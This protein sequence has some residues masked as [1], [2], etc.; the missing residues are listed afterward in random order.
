MD[1]NWK[2]SQLLKIKDNDSIFQ[3]IP[4]EIGDLV[5][6][7]TDQPNQKAMSKEDAKKRKFW[8]ISI[9]II[10]LA[11]Y[12]VFLYDHYIWGII[13]SAVVIFFTIGFSDTTFSGTDF[14]VGTEGFAIVK[15]IG[16]RDNIISTKIILFK[17][18]ELFFTGEVIEKQNYVYQRTN[19]YFSIYG[20]YNDENQKYSLLYNLE[21]DYNDKKPKDP[22][23]PKNA[24]N[25][26]CMMKIVE[27]VWS[28]HF[29]KEHI[30]DEVVNFSVYL[31]EDDSLYKDAIKIFKNEIEVYGTRY[32][33]ATTKD[34]YVSNG[35][36]VIEHINHSK[37]WFG[38]VEKGNISYV[39]LTYL[40]NRESFLAFFYSLYN[41]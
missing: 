10:L 19:F 25:E 35:Q 15:F 4:S 39:P 40:G 17:D 27:A 37:K 1:K 7:D 23:N 24:S 41:K 2:D 3:F 30:N 28:K 22:F 38:F 18:M 20:K 36:L 12:W 8:A 31:K 6:C 29:V 11:L 14:F 21:G 16:S 32:S 5:Y 9:C 34:I 26:Y 33:K 13:F